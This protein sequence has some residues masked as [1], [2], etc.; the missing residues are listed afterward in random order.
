MIRQ[1]LQDL[2]GE[3]IDA[4]RGEYRINSPY[5]NDTKFHLYINEEKWKWYDQHESKG[6]DLVSFLA[7]HLEVPKEEVRDHILKSYY[8]NPSAIKPKKI[9]TTKEIKNNKPNFIPDVKWFKNGD[10]SSYAMEFIKKRNLPEEA[11][12]Q[13]G[14]IH[15]PGY[16]NDHLF[17]PFVENG[18]M[19]WWIYRDYSWCAVDNYKYP[20]NM[21]RKGVVYN[22]DRI[23]ENSTVFIFESVLDALMLKEQIGT[24]MNGS[25]LDDEQA[26]K[27]MNKKPGKIVFVFDKDDTGRKTAVR[28]IEKFKNY[29]VDLYLF[30]NFEGKDF[31][32]SGEHF[33]D[34]EECLFI[35]NYGGKK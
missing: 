21:A 6:G 17:I 16:Y 13:L 22:I 8:K 18:T 20:K 30:N 27:I 35:K 19:K 29:N 23:K 11:I 14:F 2:F 32:E 5:F 4:P 34:E 12:N 1:I 31:G 24:S 7:E 15:E 28:N 10:Y 26:K 3:V 33:I 25:S 9:K